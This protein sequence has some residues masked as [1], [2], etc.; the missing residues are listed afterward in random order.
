MKEKMLTVWREGDVWFDFPEANEQ[1][2]M[3]M[4]MKRDISQKCIIL[5]QGEEPYQTKDI[6]INLIQKPTTTKPTKK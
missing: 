5:P 3:D 6:E 2:V 4:L 1:N